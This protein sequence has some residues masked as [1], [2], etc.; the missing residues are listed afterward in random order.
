MWVSFFSA[1]KQP[2]RFPLLCLLLHSAKS[3]LFSRAQC[4]PTPLL[5]GVRPFKGGDVHTWRGRP[6]TRPRGAGA[7]PR[8]VEPA[9][10]KAG[11]EP[12]AMEEHSRSSKESTE[13]NEYT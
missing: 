10:G 12:P 3:L 5:G 13:I 9:E 4:L 11:R 8:W 2:G 6:H 7:E 1:R